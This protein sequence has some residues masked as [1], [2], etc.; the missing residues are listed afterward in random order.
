[1]MNEKR[2]R[3]VQEKLH[4]VKE[5]L[6]PWRPLVNAHMTNFISQNYWVLLPEGVRTESLLLSNHEL[7]DIFWN[8]G[9]NPEKFQ[10]PSQI[11]KF[12]IDCW[13]LTLASNYMNDLKAGHQEYNGLFKGQAKCMSPKKLHE[14]NSLKEVVSCL[15]ESSDADCVV[16]V[17][18]GKGYLGTSLVLDKNINVLSIDSK[19]IN[20]KGALH[21]FRSIEKDACTENGPKSL[22][23]QITAFVTPETSL[24]SLAS[25]HLG[26]K[27]DYKICLTGLHVCGDLAST[28]I[29]LFCKNSDVLSMC[30]IGCCYNLLTEKFESDIKLEESVNIPGFPMSKYLTDQCYFLG[31]NAR[32]LACQSLDR[33]CDEKRMMKPNLF[34]RAVLQVHLE[35]LFGP[36]CD[37]TVGRRCSKATSLMDYLLIAQKYLKKDLQLTEE[38]VKELAEEMHMFYDSMAKFYCFRLALAPVVE[39]LIILDKLL[40]LHEQGVDRAYIYKVFDAVQS[41]RCHGLIAVKTPEYGGEQGQSKW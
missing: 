24:R 28:C 6:E 40:Y 33:I 26:T 5:F 14:I 18:G 13:N 36:E 41:P 20:T 10:L 12:L 27:S 23:R 8:W 21:I 7:H 16:D 2:T 37:L 35:R 32:M 3:V 38:K 9:S 25:E 31:R 22:Y 34:W 19:P 11:G 29:E 1:M 30:N 17:G 39:T 4:Q 15:C